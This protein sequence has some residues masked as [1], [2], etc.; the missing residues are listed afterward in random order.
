MATERSEGAPRLLAMWVSRAMGERSWRADLWA[1]VAELRAG[2]SVLGRGVLD[3]G[4][5]LG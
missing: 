5:L 2:R 4:V 1:H 3:G